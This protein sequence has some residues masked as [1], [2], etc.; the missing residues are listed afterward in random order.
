MQ[1]SDTSDAH[2]GI[3]FYNNLWAGILVEELR[4]GGISDFCIAPGSRSAPL[5]IACAENPHIRVHL[6]F[7][8]RGL[9]YYALGLAK[10][11]GKP[12]AVIT[13]SGTAV[14]NLLPAVTEAFLTHAPLILLT[15]DR[16]AELT[17]SGANQVIRQ[18][19]I[20]ASCTIWHITMA[21]PCSRIDTR[22]VAAIAARA[23][24]SARRAALPV[25]LNCPFAEPLYE[26][27]DA[28][29]FE[30]LKELADF[31]G[32]DRPRANRR[33]AESAEAEIRLHRDVAEALAGPGII[34]AGRL[35][36][37]D[38]A[39]AL[40]EIADHLG[41]QVLPDAQSQ[42]R[43]SGKA[44]MYADLLLE[45]PGFRNAMEAMPAAL[46]F[47]GRFVSRNFLRLAKGREGRK[48]VMVYPYSDY[49][50]P[51]FSADMLCQCSCRDF[52]RALRKQI[53]RRGGAQEAKGDL[54]CLLNRMVSALVDGFCE[55]FSEV[56]V[57]RHISRLTGPLMLGN[58]L[59]ARIFSLAADENSAGLVY[60]NRGASGI[61]GV[62]ATA[63][64]IAAAESHSVTLLTG[65]TSAL[66]DLNSLAL[67]ASEKL[68]V[69]VINNSGGNI[70]ATLP[71][72][73][74]SNHLERYFA[75]R[76]SL[77]FRHAAAMFGL[78]YHPVSS[79]EELDAVYPPREKK[80]MLL[81][82]EIP[83]NSTPRLVARLKEAARK[84]ELPELTGISSASLEHADS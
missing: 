52:L 66:H 30:R 82:C 74:A 81:E 38:E 36:S 48:T 84:L 70:F 67:A 77:N 26:T 6:H 75:L 12:V 19:E 73:G 39:V 4:R 3:A 34:L 72:A 18:H 32:G 15:A 49:P 46:I 29:A 69:L 41:W 43:Q 53:P 7:D 11:T 27:P 31:A 8:E 54:T 55:N 16:P 28:A 42:L 47:S 14:P 76:H 83:W 61:D 51:D 56:S 59:P 78:E 40:L 35:E 24:D 5:A 20:F 79:L 25:H 45:S 13:T 22:Y 65:D 62:T 33:G 50:D 58:S 9:A 44:L 80:A 63:A 37:R 71:G 2:R 23:A 1:Q 21:E 10:A 68:C 17:D 57:I 60:S 64:G